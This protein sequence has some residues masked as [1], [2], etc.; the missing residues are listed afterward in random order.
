MGYSTSLPSIG[1][2]K[3]LL[4]TTEQ[5]VFGI[6]M[7]FNRVQGESRNSKIPISKSRRSQDPI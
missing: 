4:G 2:D 1:Q 7:Y 6:Y 5:D 3:H